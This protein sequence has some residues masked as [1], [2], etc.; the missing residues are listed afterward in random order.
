[1]DAMPLQGSLRESVTQA[2]VDLRAG[3][4]SASDRLWSFVYR[5]LHSLAGSILRKERRA[6]LL[7]TTALLHETYVKLTDQT[8]VVWRDRLHFFRFAAT[9]MRRILVDWARREGAVKRGKGFQRVD[10]TDVITP[11]QLDPDLLLDLDEALCRLAVIRERCVRIV[12]L[13]YFAGMSMG[14]IAETLD[15]SLTTVEGDWQFARTWLHRELSRK[16]D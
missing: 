9:A 1:M 10:L 7:E 4:A 6:S 13:R 8:R 11:E 3:D 5:D 15:V 12:E 2:L 16:R 14:E